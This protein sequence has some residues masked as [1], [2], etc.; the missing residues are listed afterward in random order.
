MI[1]RLLDMMILNWFKKN[2]FEKKLQLK[3]HLLKEKNQLFHQK[4][5]NHVLQNNHQNQY[6][7][8]FHHHHHQY[9]HQVHH[10]QVH[11]HQVHQERFQKVCFVFQLVELVELEE[12]EVLQQN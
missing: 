5:L 8:Q 1:L 7:H 12:V 3:N 2:H 11:H 10:H 4:I 6:H 9:H